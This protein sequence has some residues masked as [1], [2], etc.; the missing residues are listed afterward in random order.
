M[1]R[2]LAPSGEAQWLQL[3][4]WP[5]ADHPEVHAWSVSPTGISL[6]LPA[7]AEPYQRRPLDRTRT[8]HEMDQ[9]TAQEVPSTTKQGGSPGHREEAARERQ[10]EERESG[11]DGEGGTRPSGLKHTL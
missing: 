7:R 10:R 3:L 8:V 9:H 5:P 4:R 11:L 1:C 6:L 2:K